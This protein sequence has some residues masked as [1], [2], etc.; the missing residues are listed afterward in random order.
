M[1]FLIQPRSQNNGINDWRDQEVLCWDTDFSQSLFVL[2]FGRSVVRSFVR[3]FVRSLV[4][5]A[6]ARSFVR[7]FAPSFV[8]SFLPARS[9]VCWFVSSFVCSSIRL[10][11]ASNF[12]SSNLTSGRSD[13]R[14]SERITQYSLGSWVGKY[15]AQFELTKEGMRLWKQFLYRMDIF[16]RVKIFWESE[17]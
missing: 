10:A 16:N 7:S 1:T 2:S 8:R 12:I 5:R 13:A 9:S 3:A 6:L 15:E 17:I 14:T 4:A 11:S